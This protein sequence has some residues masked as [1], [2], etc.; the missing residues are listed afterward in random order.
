MFVA[1]DKELGARVTSLDP[2]WQIRFEELRAL[3][4]AGRLVCPGCGQLL[5]FR[6]GE[7]RRPHFAHRVLSECPL[8]KQ[9]PEVL[10]AKAQLY[11][12]L[13]GKYPEKVELDV[14]LMIPEWN[15]F[16]DLLVRRNEATSFAY[17]VFDRS[18]RDR[19]ALLYNMPDRVSRN[20]IFTQAAHHRKENN[21]LLLTA[22]QRDLIG[23]SDYNESQRRG[24]L[25][26]LNTDTKKTV[27]YRGLHCVHKP[28]M[29][30][31]EAMREAALAESLICP[32]NGEIVFKADVEDRQKRQSEAKAARPLVTTQRE[33]DHLSALQPESEL[34]DEVALLNR[35]L[36]CS[37]C[38]IET[39]DYAASAPANGSCVC[40]N[41]LPQYLAARLKELKRG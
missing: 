35:P 37:V 23:N 13:T 31:W 16:A 15:R 26:F 24:H 21:I 10:E 20:I 8:A 5:R 28:N 12:W 7:Q 30:A 27:L 3:A 2:A 11:E 34:E 33:S 18:P 41:C 17:W 29:Y 38:G 1:K 19:Y 4:G 39:T 14:N 6:V 22:G 32:N 9:S 36:K 25:H 40:R